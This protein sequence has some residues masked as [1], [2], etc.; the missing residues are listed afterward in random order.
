M[1]KTEHLSFTVRCSAFTLNEC[2]REKYKEL[3]LDPK[4]YR[5]SV[6][7]SGPFSQIKD[8]YVRVVKDR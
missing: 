8:H 1:E 5:F 3:D 7:A 4:K 6:T 2:I